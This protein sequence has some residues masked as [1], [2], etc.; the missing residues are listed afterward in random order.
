MEQRCKIAILS[1]ERV[2]QLA[3]ALAPSA[4]PLEQV[5]ISIAPYATEIP[6]IS[7][8]DA[9]NR[10]LLKGGARGAMDG[11]REVLGDQVQMSL[12]VNTEGLWQGRKREFLE[13]VEHRFPPLSMMV[14]HSIFLQERLCLGEGCEDDFPVNG[15]VLVVECGEK[16]LFL[17][18]HCATCAN[19]TRRKQYAIPQRPPKGPFTEEQLEASFQQLK[20]SADTMCASL[21]ELQPARDLFRAM[22]SSGLRPALLA[23]PLPRAIISS[24]SLAV[25][26]SEQQLEKLQQV[27]SCDP[28]PDAASLSNYQRAY[29]CDGSLNKSPYCNGRPGDAGELAE[30]LQKLRTRAFSVRAPALQRG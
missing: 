21:K 1:Q 6:F 20:S 15:G 7:D 24:A 3:R 17:V 13:L 9:D 28:V 4:A 8:G 11:V 30:L 2:S 16:L 5:S 19:V 14:S 18:R 26:I 22:Y 29:T 25:D 12:L 27:F 10:R 23:S